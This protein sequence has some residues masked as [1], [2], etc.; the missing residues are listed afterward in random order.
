MPTEIPSQD[1][2]L[3]LFLLVLFTIKHFLADF[4]FQTEYMLRKGHTKGWQRP[5]A[6]HCAVHA[7]LTFLVTF[8]PI[9]LWAVGLAAIDFVIHFCVDYWKAQIAR[10]PLNSRAFWISLGADQLLHYLTYIALAYIAV[11]FA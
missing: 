6:A 7:A 10:Y 2:A 5:L 1:I 11:H 8:T 9:G 4:V 3:V